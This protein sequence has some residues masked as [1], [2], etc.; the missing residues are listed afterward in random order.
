MFAICCGNNWIFVCCIDQNLIHDYEERIELLQS[1]L[2]NDTESKLLTS[3]KQIF[4]TQISNF[5]QQILKLEKESMSLKE[6][7]KQLKKDIEEIYSKVGSMNQYM[8]KA[9]TDL[10]DVLGLVSQE[11]LSRGRMSDVLDTIEINARKAHEKINFNRSLDLD[12]ISRN[13]IKNNSSSWQERR[14][15]R[16]EKQELLTLQVQLNN[17][18]AVKQKAQSELVRLQQE[19][20]KI[21]NQL[22]EAQVEIAKLCKQVKSKSHDSSSN[23]ARLVESDNES[24]MFLKDNFFEQNTLLLVNNNNNT[25]SSSSRDNNNKMKLQLRQPSVTTHATGSRLSEVPSTSNMDN[26]DYQ[27]KHGHSFIIR[28]FITPIKCYICTSLMIGLVRQG[29]VCEVC[30]YACHVGCVDLGLPC[31]FDETKQRMIGIDPQKGIGTAYEGYVKIPKPRGG[32]RKGWVRMFVVV[33]DFKL[34][35]YDAHPDSLSSGLNYGNLSNMDSSLM[36]SP[37]VSAN[38]IIDMR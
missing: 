12:T 22:N 25:G 19:Y 26:F 24:N 6:Q 10:Q 38:T 34:F 23:S 15:A 29:Y 4:L 36:N 13:F 3:E 1:K 14:M 18:I 5:E 37:S 20:D 2:K 9:E 21:S 30:G 31:P 32:I 8:Y 35:L 33:C 27:D 28:T 17:E 16:V 11:Q 7:N